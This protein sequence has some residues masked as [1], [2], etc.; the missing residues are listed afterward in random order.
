VIKGAVA[1]N[2][3]PLVTSD[4]ASISEESPLTIEATKE[5]E[6]LLFDLT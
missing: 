3:T 1:V 6:S 4:G 2:G 5:A